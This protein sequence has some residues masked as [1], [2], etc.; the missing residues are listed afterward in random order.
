MTSDTGCIATDQAHADSAAV[1]AGLAEARGKV[2]EAQQLLGELF[3]A[4][5]TSQD[6]VFGEGAMFVDVPQ[7]R[8]EGALMQAAWLAMSGAGLVLDVLEGDARDWLPTKALTSFAEASQRVAKVLDQEAYER[9]VRDHPLPR[10]SGYQQ[11]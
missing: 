5:P 10:Y 7:G 8:S 6:R 9:Y 3:K 1:L 11:D 2:L 4:G